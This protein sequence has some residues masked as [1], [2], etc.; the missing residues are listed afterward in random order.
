MSDKYWTFLFS[1]SNLDFYGTLQKYAHFPEING[2]Q[3]L[4][5]VFKIKQNEC[6]IAGPF[7]V[8]FL[9]SLL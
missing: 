4:M 5:D 9:E 2:C 6:V 7:I 3:R 1:S 8:L